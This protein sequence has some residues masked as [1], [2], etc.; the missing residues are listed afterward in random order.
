[1]AVNLD[2]VSHVSGATLLTR[3]VEL[4]K[5]GRYTESLVFYESGIQQLM[6]LLKSKGNINIWLIHCNTY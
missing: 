5:A 4:D 6:V 1:M 3:A 2:L